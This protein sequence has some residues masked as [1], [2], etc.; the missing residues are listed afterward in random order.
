[1]AT[2]NDSHKEEMGGK[3]FEQGVHKVTI[4]LIEADKT[5]DGKEYFEVTVGNDDGAEGSARLWFHTDGSIKYSFN[6]LRNIFVHNA[7]TEADKEK[8]RKKVDALKNTDEL[9][10]ACA[11]LIG[12]ECWYEVY[13]NKERKFIGNDG[14]ERY[15]YDRNIYGYEPKAKEVEENFASDI[16]EEDIQEADDNFFK[17]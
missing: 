11:M 13:E 5:D 7:K 12:K 3:Y 1:M 15:S 10:K 14:K 4:L 6:T 8:M 2:F 9:E 16:K 17:D